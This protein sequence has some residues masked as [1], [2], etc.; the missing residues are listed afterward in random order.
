VAILIV[1][2]DIIRTQSGKRIDSG[3]PATTTD[4]AAHS[5]GASI[6][7]TDPKQAR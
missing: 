6:T 4:Q 3:T 1:L 2:L 7:P 5:A